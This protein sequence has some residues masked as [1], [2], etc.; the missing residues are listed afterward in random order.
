MNICK[1]INILAFQAFI[2]AVLLFALPQSAFSECEHHGKGGKK[3]ECENPHG[4]C[5]MGHGECPYK[6]MKS[7]LSLTDEQAEAMRKVREENKSKFNCRE[8][9]SKKETHECWSKM[10]DANRAAFANILDESQLAKFD[11]MKA[12]MM[13]K[14]KEHMHHHG[15]KKDRK[16]DR[17]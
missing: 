15:H 14:K 16:K 11:E 6:E 3:A 5:C 2:V 7:K 10:M 8:L 17:T 9:D 4:D 12:S 13:E 1:K